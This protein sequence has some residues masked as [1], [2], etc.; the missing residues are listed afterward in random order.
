MK[1]IFQVA[2][3]ALLAATDVSAH[4]IFQDLW[5]DGVDMGSQCVRMPKSNSP[6]T[7]VGSAD[8]RC[9]VGGTAGVSGKCAVS[10]GSTVSVEMHQVRISR[11]SVKNRN[12]VFCLC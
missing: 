11:P 9:N 12:P 8:I 4:A 7:N 6:V 1:S 2:I 10:A 3:V 5:V